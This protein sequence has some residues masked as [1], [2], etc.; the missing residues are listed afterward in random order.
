MRQDGVIFLIDS[1]SFDK[2]LMR[3]SIEKL[4]NCKVFNF[5]SLDEATL[6]LKLNPKAII[7]SSDN[8]VGVEN[9][10]VK[11]DFIDISERI[12]QEGKNILVRHTTLADK[13]TDLLKKN[14]N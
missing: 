1:K 2:D 5:F 7:Y 3:L 10:P 12:N 13:L 11:V 8:H 6:Y 9:F 4:T 14:L